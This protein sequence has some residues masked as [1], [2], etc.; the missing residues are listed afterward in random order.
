MALG[1]CAVDDVRCTFNQ[2]AAVCI[3]NTQ[4]KFSMF[5]TGNKVGIE[6][7]SQ[8]AYMH[9]TCGRRS[10]TGAYFSGWNLFFVIFK[11]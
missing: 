5:M 10:K 4:D 1:H 6:C 7:R 8:I 11:P 3:F 9:I 2:A